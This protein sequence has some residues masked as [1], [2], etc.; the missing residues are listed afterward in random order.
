MGADHPHPITH[1]FF[2]VEISRARDRVEL[3]TDD[4]AVWKTMR[5]RCMAPSNGRE[6][7]RRDFLG[8]TVSAHLTPDIPQHRLGGPKLVCLHPI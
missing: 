6:V 1:K 2:Y 7:G 5:A 4:K 3:V 8:R